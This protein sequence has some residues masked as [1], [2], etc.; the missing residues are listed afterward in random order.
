M[1]AVTVTLLLISTL[2]KG[3]LRLTKYHSNVKGALIGIPI[4]D[5]S[6]VSELGSAADGSTEGPLASSSDTLDL[7]APV[8]LTAQ[9]FLKGLYR[10]KADWDEELALE[11]IVAW[12]EWLHGL[13]GLTGL[14][15]PRCIKPRTLKGPYRM[16][17]HSFSDAP[18]AGY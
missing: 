8:L 14:R 5:L 16:E 1:Q 13:A 3:D 15:S 18:E 4:E 11:E 2:L 12:R 6:Y 7:V 17:L 10:R 9:R